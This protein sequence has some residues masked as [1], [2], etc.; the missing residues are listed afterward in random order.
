MEEKHRTINLIG[1]SGKIGS[2]KDTVGGVLQLYFA[3]HQPADAWEIKKFAGKLKDI[4]EILTGIPKVNFEM[5][6]FKQSNLPEE[7][8]KNGEPMT[9]RSLLQIVGTDAMRDQLHENVWVNA[10]FADYNENSRWI[11]TDVRFPNEAEAI[12]KHGGIVI[13]INRDVDTNNHLSET[14]LDDYEFDYVI[15]NNSDM[16]KL[17][18]DVKAIAEKLV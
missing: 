1:I 18:L 7:W 12:K 3:T 9:A 5:Q 15:D 10:L 16:Y 11:I 2:G 17:A 6:H 4:A 14:A 13:R 8:N